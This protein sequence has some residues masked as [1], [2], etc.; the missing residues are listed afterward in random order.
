[1]LRIKTKAGSRGFTSGVEDPE[2]TY[3]LVSSLPNLEPDPSL[4]PDE[5]LR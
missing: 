4:F 2:P 5:P 3:V 1:V